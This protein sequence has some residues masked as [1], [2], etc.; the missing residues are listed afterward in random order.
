M[1]I[2]SWLF[3]TDADRLKKARDLMAQGR[4]EAARQKLLHCH[5]PEAEKLYEQC[6]AA[7]DKQERGSLKKQLASQGFHGWKIEVTM[8]N[9]RRRADLEKMVAEEL[10][11]AGVDLDLPELDQAA[12]K[13]AIA[14]AEKRLRN[15]G[16]GGTA[17]VRLVP[18]TDGR[19]ARG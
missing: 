10:E 14:R 15:K 11:R 4:F 8:Q 17:A 1:G 2:L 5:A 12:A 13:T 6:S 19:L 9:A 18:V 7:V 3:P 16:G